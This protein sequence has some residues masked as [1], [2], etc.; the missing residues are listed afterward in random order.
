[1]GEYQMVLSNY[2]AQLH[3]IQASCSMCKLLIRM[4]YALTNHAKYAN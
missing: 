2:M 1:M 3:Q 4:L